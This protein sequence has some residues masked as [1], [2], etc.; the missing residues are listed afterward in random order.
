MGFS[1]H[2]AVPGSSN[3]DPPPDSTRTINNRGDANV[4]DLQSGQIQYSGQRVLKFKLH[5]PG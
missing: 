4:G 2:D 1:P 3:P 5:D